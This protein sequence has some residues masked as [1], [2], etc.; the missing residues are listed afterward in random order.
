MSN[1]SSDSERRIPYDAWLRRNPPHPGTYVRTAMEDADGNRMTVAEAARKLGV[2]VVAI[3]R[4]LNGRSGIS[5]AMALRFEAIGWGMADWWW[6]L[7]SSY[8]LAQARNKADQW[9]AEGDVEAHEH[10]PEEVGVAPV[11]RSEAA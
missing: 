1:D 11:A 10:R 7:Q 4:V 8:D 5:A 6:D 9:P 3:S 2:S